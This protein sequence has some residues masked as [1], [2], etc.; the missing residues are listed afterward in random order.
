[1]TL[2]LPVLFSICSGHELLWRSYICTHC[3]LQLD[4]LGSTSTLTAF[5]TTSQRALEVLEK[6]VIQ[7]EAS[8]MANGKQALAD[9]S[10]NEE[11]LTK[12]L[13]K[14]RHYPSFSFTIC[15]KIQSVRIY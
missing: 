3:L 10:S 7:V 13:R 15:F 4:T 8:R 5:A 6:E 1:M 14:V 9:A 12:E 2:Y 11:E